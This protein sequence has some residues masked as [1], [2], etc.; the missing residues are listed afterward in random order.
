M[1]DEDDI[2][3]QDETRDRDIP[4]RSA[5]DKIPPLS[6]AS[7]FSQG[8]HG[9]K[10]RFEGD[11][12]SP[13]GTPEPFRSSLPDEW[14]RRETGPESRRTSFDE[15]EAGGLPSTRRDGTAHDEFGH[16]DGLQ[17]RRAPSECERFAYYCI[18][19][20]RVFLG[21]SARD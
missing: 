14:S 20:L 8:E 4:P 15:E 6:R 16:D 3:A 1:Q 9:A 21:H 18:C 17:C 19:S 7:S 2:K 13:E 5:Q 11:N 12:K 10:Q